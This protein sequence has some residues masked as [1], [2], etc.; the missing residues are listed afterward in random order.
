M[1]KAE[2]KKL[3]SVSYVA[4]I[5]YAVH[6]FSLYFILSTYLDRYFS[7]GTLSLLFAIGS[8][9]C[10][11]ASNYFGKILKKY[12]N[13]K[14]LIY[15]LI[16]QFLVTITLAFSDNLNLFLIA[17]FFI[18]HYTLYSVIS[19]SINV[20]I[21]EFSDDENV[22]AIRGTV[23]TIH[24]FGAILSPFVSSQIFHLVG[25]SG[26]FIISAL[27][28]LPLIYLINTFYSKVKEPKYKYVNIFQSFN[29]VRKDRNIRGVIASSFILNS[30]YAV[31]NVYL[32]I[33]LTHDLNIPIII[34]LQL[35]VPITIIPFVLIPYQL[36]K[37]SDEI[38]GEKKPMLFGIA[39]MSIIMVSIFV[40]NITT[41]NIFVWIALIFIARIGA[42]V[43]E[44][45]NYA[46][47]YKGVDSRNAGLI[48]F[49]QNVG[50]ISF[51]FITILGAILIDSFNIDLKVL[52]FIV[53]VLG[54][55]SMF[56][57]SKIKDREVKMRKI[58]ELKEKV[59]Q[60]LKKEEDKKKMFYYFS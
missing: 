51:L 21:E 32:A 55:L 16:A 56:T 49:F 40:F 20:F 41:S 17:A 39:T 27:S 45:E 58:K 44:T 6:Y 22:G 26:L 59:E 48:A 12:T 9:T 52:F 8:F 7:E 13:K 53:G 1:P 28:V 10:I 37:Y 24:N 38:F 19:T 42:A 11:L 50:N 43:T 25:F 3:L 54:L 60:D 18:V 15:S 36:G 57:I 35:L 5:L 47:F 29:L 30:F 34:Y 4:T 2:K 14:S 33:Y 46:Y 31:V 23:L